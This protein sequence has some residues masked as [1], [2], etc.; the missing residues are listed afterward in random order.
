MKEYSRRKRVNR[1]GFAELLMRTPK[2]ISNWIANAKYLPGWARKHNN[3]PMPHV[4]PMGR[5]WR[6]KDDIEKW[7]YGN[8]KINP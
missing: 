4:D 7:F 1:K 2:T 3:F 5:L 8:D 6:F